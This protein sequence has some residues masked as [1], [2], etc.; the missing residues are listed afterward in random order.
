LQRLGP[1]VIQH[2]IASGPEFIDWKYFRRRQ[3]T[4]ER[5]DVGLF[6]QFEQFADD[7]TAHP[8][9]PVGVTIFP[10]SLHSFSFEMVL[11]ESKSLTGMVNP[12]GFGCL[13]LAKQKG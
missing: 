2:V 5:D 11:G 10:G 13:L 12:S 1:E 7:G 4:P 6:G 8:L 9:C 3:P